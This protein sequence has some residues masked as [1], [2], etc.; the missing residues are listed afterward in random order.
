MS[1]EQFSP[2]HYIAAHDVCRSLSENLAI[3]FQVIAEEA[4]REQAVE[5]FTKRQALMLVC[6]MLLDEG[7]RVMKTV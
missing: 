7:E 6:K 2:M 4:T 1:D 5:N 3:H